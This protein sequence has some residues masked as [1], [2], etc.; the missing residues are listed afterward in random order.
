MLGPVGVGALA[1]HGSLHSEAQ[2]GNHGQAAVLDLLH[3]QQQGQ[4]T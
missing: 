4:D 3:L 2:E 1:G